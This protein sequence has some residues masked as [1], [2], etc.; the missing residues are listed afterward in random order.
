MSSWLIFLLVLVLAVVMS[1]GLYRDIRDLIKGKI[2]FR[3]FF[4]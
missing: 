3:R 1:I 2:K 4:L